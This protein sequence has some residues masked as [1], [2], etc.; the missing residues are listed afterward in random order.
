[1]VSRLWYAAL[2][3]LLMNN[4]SASFPSSPGACAG[5]DGVLTLGFATGAGGDQD[6]A[7]SGEYLDAYIW[8][9]SPR[10]ATTAPPPAVGVRASRSAVKE[11]LSIT[12][13]AVHMLLA[14]V[15]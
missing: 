12:T 9:L 13:G 10:N 4:S 11:L 14:R 7:G 15:V 5:A 3:P 6:G 2:L 1:M 8:L